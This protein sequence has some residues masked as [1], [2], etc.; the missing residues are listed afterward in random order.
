MDRAFLRSEAARL[1]GVHQRVYV[2]ATGAGAGLQELLW[3]V[4]GASRFLVGAEFPYAPEATKRFLGGAPPDGFCSARTALALAMEAYY[5]ACLPDYGGRPC[6]GLGLSGSVAST[7]EHRGDH[8]VHV[9]TVTDS[10]VMSYAVKLEKGV[11]VDFRLRDGHVSDATGLYALL[12]AVGLSPAWHP[13]PPDRFDA[14]TDPDRALEIL[15]RH[16]VFRASGRRETAPANG[17]GLTIFPGTF[18]P[19]HEAHS[20]LARESQALLHV[21]IDPPHKPSM[22]V[23]EVL[24]RARMLEG[25]DRMFTRGDPLYL[26]KARRF[27]G[28]RIVIGADAFERMLD[29]RWGPK[30]GPMLAEFV[31]LGCAF[32]VAD[33]EIDGRMITVADLPLDSARAIC[34]RIRRPPEH[35]RL[36]STDIRDASATSA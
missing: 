6:V 30:I 19:P 13:A 36:S 9:A 20:W 11:G 1:L 28:A 18:N 3:D 7:R 21:T 5:R 8:R 32:L 34:T 14:R 33:R 12:A 35:L 2:V 4:P 17:N 16:P 22:T 23:G 15:E 25:H 27:P 31:R 24:R 29:P 26:D 10:E